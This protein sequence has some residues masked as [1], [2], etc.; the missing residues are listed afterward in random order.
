MKERNHYFIHDKL[1]GILMVITLSLSFFIVLSVVRLQNEQRLGENQQESE[2]Y[3][4]QLLYHGYYTDYEDEIFDQ[5]PELNADKLTIENGNVILTGVYYPVS[6]ANIYASASIVLKFNEPLVEELL[7]GRYPTDSEQKHHRNCVVIGT[8]LLKHTKKQGKERILSIDGREYDVLGV[9]EDMTGYEMDN[10]IILFY[11]CLAEKTKRS[12]DQRLSSTGTIDFKI[13]YGSNEGELDEILALESWLYQ[14]TD[15]RYFSVIENE[16][17]ENNY[18]YEEARMMREYNKYTLYLMFGFCMCACFVVSSVWVKRRR[19]E[20]VI[21]KA[22]GSSFFKV[23]SVILKDIGIMVV[24]SMLF[25]F[26]LLILQMLI[27]GEN[28]LSGMYMIQNI[29]FIGVSIGIVLVI[30][31]IRPLYTVATI[32]PAEGTRAL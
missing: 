29:Q 3:D 6:D 28:W 4:H 27:T 5:R 20:L 22:L 8:E 21:R 7:E 10:R 12:I 17:E 2:K 14:I 32:S 23:I 11:D 31:M 26:I 1:A 15:K 30:T 9:L 24:I 25:D 13:L 16:E 19:K 18:G